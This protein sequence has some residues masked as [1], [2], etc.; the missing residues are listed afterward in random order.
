MTIRIDAAGRTYSGEAPRTFTIGRDT[1]CDIVT[2]ELVVSRRHAEIRSTATGWEVVDLGSSGGTRLGGQPLAPHVPAP[3][4][5]TTAIELGQP[6][7]GFVLSVTVVGTPPPADV[8]QVGATGAFAPP[9]V[10]VAAPAP[11][12]DHG[13]DV[14][15]LP[16]TGGPTGG[17]GA[18]GAPSGPGLV[19]RLR[20]GDLQFLPGQPVRIGRDSGNEVVTDNPS[21][22]RLHA[23]VEPRPDGWWLVD[24]STAGTYVDGERVTSRKI[25]RPTTVLLGHPTAGYELELVPVVEAHVASA[26]I[27]RTKRRRTLAVVGAA[28]AVLVLVGG[29]VAAAVLLG[30][31]DDPEPQA[32]ASQPAGQDQPADE[33]GAGLS[34]EELDRAKAATVFLLAYGPDGQPLHSGSGSVISEDGLIL[35]N[36]HVADSD[37]PGQGGAELAYVEV[38]FT[39]DDDDAPVE[40]RYV[41]EPIVS[42]G[43][44]DIAIAKITT[45][46]E[47]NPVDAADLDL[48]EPLPLGDSDTLETAD[49]ITALGYPA[50]TRVATMTDDPPTL[51]V[52]KGTVA[53]FNADDVIGSPRA[54][55]DADLRIGSGNSGGPSINDE[56]E[57]IGLN[58]RV[59][60]EGTVGDSGEGGAF[61]GG[62]AR[63]VPVNLAEAVLEIAEAGGDPAYVSP[64]LDELPD[65]DEQ[66]ASATIEQ[67][68]WSPDGS[69]GTCTGTSTIE[70]PQVVSVAPGDTVHAEFT[71]TGLP[72]DT[73]I[74]F[75][76]FTLDGETELQRDQVTWDGSLD[77]QCVWFS[78]T[79]PEGVGGINAVPQVGEQYVVDNPLAFQ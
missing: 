15:R 3:L 26:G 31:D 9:V 16:P 66:M 79:V 6:G 32:G 54:E 41:A 49:E 52:T 14:T 8:T 40:L 74:D 73:P 75:V 46:A 53:A 63:V 18:Y 19:V 11:S 55:I 34:Q 7:S 10:P 64:Y 5:G 76:L 36:A 23:V 61:T 39:S 47:G 65:P 24:R 78:Y 25:T 60:T 45:D 68:G 38:Y 67:H 71:I 51:T 42:D 43:Y 62:S 44:L 57:V 29:G 77:G 72:A 27:A 12:Y 2:E 4:S 21:A 48:P 59:V 20:S 28:L 35:T 30:G 70:Q 58:T 56:G 22:S 13:Q 1:A 69:E 17:P 37:A 50:L 33:G